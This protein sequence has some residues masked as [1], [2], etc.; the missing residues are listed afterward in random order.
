MKPRHSRREFLQTTA[1][2][3][4]ALAS[5]RTTGAEAAKPHPEGAIDCQSHMYPEVLLD[6]M[7]KRIKPPL[8]FRRGD[9]R[10]TVVGQWHRRVRAKHMD[11]SAK[12]ADMD[13]VGIAT[14]ALT[15]NDPGPETFGADGLEM[16]Q[17]ANDFLG[18][19]A[20]AH[21]GRFIPLAFLPLQDMDA[22]LKEL[23]RCVNQLGARGILLYSNLNGQFPDEPQFRPLF[24]RAE[25]MGLPLFLHPA[26]P[27]T[28]EVT[29]G[30]NLIA[31]LGLMFDTTIALARMIL[32]G[33]LEQH[34]K[35]K[36]VCPHVGGTLPYLIGR[37]DHQTMVLKRG[38]ENIKK[39]PSEYLKQVWLDVVT[40]LPLAIKFAYDMVGPDKLLYGSDHPWVDPAL[41]MS[42]VKSL[43]LPAEDERKIFRD[44]A[45]K[46]F[47]L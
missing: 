40:P 21:P 1:V 44:N 20:K 19:T 37:L 31:G 46:L 34:P 27:V 6:F 14:T 43:G 33:I 45:V 17:L 7:E 25:E 39:A 26:D 4:M 28:F 41:I 47:G 22:S 8:V 10:Y 9:Q 24:V 16:A 12:L 36:L 11:V 2:G 35:L 15:I 42:S 29:K 3:G 23:D 30:R 18:E 13:R 5:A 32:A 38:A